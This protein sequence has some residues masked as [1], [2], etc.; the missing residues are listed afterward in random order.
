MIARQTIIKKAHAMEQVVSEVDRR[1]TASKNRQLEGLD[2]ELK[3]FSFLF[4]VSNRIKW[5]HSLGS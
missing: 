5:D 4:F 3:V 1:E 2:H